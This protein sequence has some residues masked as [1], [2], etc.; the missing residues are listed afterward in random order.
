ML[1]VNKLRLE[2]LN[3]ILQD[4]PSLHLI[5]RQ[6]DLIDREKEALRS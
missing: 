2:E 6:I 5:D 1:E 3:V 4:K